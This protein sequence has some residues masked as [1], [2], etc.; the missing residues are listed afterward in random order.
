MPLVRGYSLSTLCLAIALP[1][2]VFGQLVISTR[3]GVVHFFEGSVFLGDQ[4][5]ERRFGRFPLISDGAELRTVDGRAEIL[6]TPGVF[7]RLGENSAIHML[8]TNL[9]DTR[10]EFLAGSAILES[11]ELRPGTSVTL[12]YKHWQVG[13]PHTG[14]YRI[15]SEPARLTVQHGEAEV[16]TEGDKTVVAVKEGMVL[17]LSAVLVPER[18]SDENRDT[19]GNWALGR[20]ESVSADNSIAAQIVDDPSSMDIPRAA[21]EGFAYYPLIGVPS[22]GA[23]LT[24][25][26]RLWTPYQSGFNSIYLPGYTFRPLYMGLPGR[27]AA[28]LRPHGPTIGSPPRVGGGVSRPVTPGPIP[29]PTPPRIGGGRVGIR[30]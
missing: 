15:D 22:L 12:S 3:S 14:V 24:N 23:G 21:L 7:L 25:Q 4:Q 18:S 16:H 9:S 30:R 19:L 28:P 29:R 11:A 20:S 26:Y 6:L 5:L 1:L 27:F 17:P 13:F 2:P 10:V 8:S